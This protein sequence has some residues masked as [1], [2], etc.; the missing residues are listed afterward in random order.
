MK[1]ITIIIVLFLSFLPLTTYAWNTMG[2]RIIAQIAYDNL[3][4]QAKLKSE[5]LI[6]YLANAYP[7]S[8]SFQMAS[9]WPDF[10]KFE[11]IHI[12]DSWHFYDQ[13][14]ALD[15]TPTL[16]AP[17]PNIITALNQSII[18]LKNPDTSQYEKAFFIRFL[19]H[20]TGDAHQPLHSINFFSKTY[21]Q[22]D[23]GGN[24]EPGKL[25]AQWDN[26][27]GLFDHACGP[28]PSKSQ[29]TKCFAKQLEAEYSQ[30]YFKQKATDLAPENW[31]E[32][33]FTLAKTAVF[34]EESTAQ[35]QEYAKQQLALAGY[36]LA[37]I[38]NTVF[39]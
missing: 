33:S 34:S 7:Y 31:L 14:Y 8:S 1:I 36:R 6:N 27:L 22:G 4:P 10:L 26:V 19:L 2:H 39:A 32:E 16:P 24:L 17:T 37:N 13:P 29:Q 28:I 20:L 3:T 12:Y 9:A 30:D 15:N 35:K 38:L 25:H 18:A 11:N 5:E 21:P 23:Q